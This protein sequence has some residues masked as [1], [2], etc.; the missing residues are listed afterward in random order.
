MI[1]IMV[2]L[3]AI[4]VTLAAIMI[5]MLLVSVLLAIVIQTFLK[6]RAIRS[7]LHLIGLASQRNINLIVANAVFIF[8]RNV[9]D[10]AAS[11]FA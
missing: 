9:A 5:S 10:F 6:Q 7:N 1:P 2:T 4:M 8:K 3:V 11:R